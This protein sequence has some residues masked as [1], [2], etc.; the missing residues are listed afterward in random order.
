MINV[1]DGQGG[2]TDGWMSGVRPLN[3]KALTFVAPRL[4]AEVWTECGGFLMCCRGVELLRY[5]HNVNLEIISNVR[6]P[7]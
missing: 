3:D 5:W 4:V 7:L 6:I 2:W 1:K